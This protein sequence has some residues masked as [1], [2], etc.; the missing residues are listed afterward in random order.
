VAL[1]KSRDLSFNLGKAA[2]SVVV[3]FR[4]GIADGFGPAAISGNTS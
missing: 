4:F 1:Y 2:R 3:V